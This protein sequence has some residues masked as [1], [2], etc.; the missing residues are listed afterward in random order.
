MEAIF[1]IAI[2]VSIT[3]AQLFYKH[4]EVFVISGGI[5]LES[6][7]AERVIASLINCIYEIFVNDEKIGYENTIFMVS[8]E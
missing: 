2:Y 3:F 1:L 5:Q 4:N 8:I 7:S 6:N